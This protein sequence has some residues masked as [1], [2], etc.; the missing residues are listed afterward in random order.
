[1]SPRIKQPPNPEKRAAILEAALELFAEYGFH[2]TAVPQVAEKARVG[3]GTVYRYFASKEALV[4]E[5]YQEWKMRLG[6]AL[7]EDFPVEKPIRAQ[8]HEI[9]ARLQRF[10][11]RHPKALD[12][13]EL[14]HHGSYLDEE[15]LAVEKSM[16]RPLYV[17]A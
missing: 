11:T 10:A 14:H 16:L 8:F 5:L 6:L 1:M 17:F 9:W 13:L 3:A 15:S 4:N 2:G 12:F 7:V